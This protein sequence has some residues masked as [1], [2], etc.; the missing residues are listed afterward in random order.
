ADVERAAPTLKH[1]SPRRILV[2]RGEPGGADAAVSADGSA[3]IAVET[4]EDVHGVHPLLD[5]AEFL[6][7][8]ALVVP[9]G[10]AHLAGEGFRRG[11][12]GNEPGAAAALA[13]FE[14]TALLELAADRRRRDPDTETTD[15]LLRAARE[16]AAFLASEDRP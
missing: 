9:G 12:L 7:Q 13:A 8:L 6:A 10:D 16:R 15:R 3:R 4:V 5:A 14:V 1:F 2:V 11:Y